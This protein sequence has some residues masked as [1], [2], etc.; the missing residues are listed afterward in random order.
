M[1]TIADWIAQHAQVRPGATA[2]VDDFGALNYRELDIRIAAAAG[3]LA[4]E[5]GI[6]RGDV[7]AWLGHNLNEQIILTFAAARIG[8]MIVPLNWRLAVPELA[9][10]VQ[11]A[12]VKVLT[13]QAAY[14]DTVP[15]LIASARGCRTVAMA[16]LPRQGSGDAGGGRMDDPLL[17]VYTSGTTG[18]P[19]G[20]VLSQHA[21][22]V[23]ALNAID[24]HGMTADDRVLTVLPMFHVGGLNIQTLPA[25]R[26]GAWVRLHERFD[27]ARVLNA[28]AEERPTLTCL[29]PATIQALAA[30]PDW[31]KTDVSS[32]RA[33]ATGSTDVPLDCIAAFQDRGVPVIQVY[34]STETG[35][36]CMYQR[37]DEAF[38]TTGSIGR[39]GKHS[40]IRIV[41]A[42][43]GDLPDGEAGEILVRGGTVASGYWHDEKETGLAF[44]D[45]WFHTGDVGLRDEHGQYWFKDRIKH[46]I[47]SGGENIY[48]AELERVL[49]QL[50]GIAEA[51]VVG[52]A[53]ERWGSVPVAV[54]V[55]NASPPTAEQILSG[56]DG[57]LA[58][59]KHPKH[60]VFTETLPRNAMG[61]VML[62]EVAALARTLLAPRR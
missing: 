60:I 58:R 30:Q 49:R 41:D 33:V 53:D 34:G 62:D 38:A 31:Q 2:L 10:I 42:E 8:A 6:A 36:V 46:V 48:P 54:I 57:R 52:C 18:R 55:A 44:R 5:C 50:P 56:F 51:A 3:F 40:G 59:Y 15:G 22:E 32:L 45:G 7:I 19:K 23:N 43:G 37:P 47:I 1:S 28:I 13:Y 9:F 12:G 20:A 27:P 24:M 25:L 61:K 11:D 17:L 16:D 14:S 26:C 21:V 39:C 4:R 29:V 35:P